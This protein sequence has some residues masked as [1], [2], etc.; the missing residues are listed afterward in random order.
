[1]RYMKRWYNKMD[2]VLQFWNRLIVFPPKLVAWMI[3]I[4]CI[5]LWVAWCV[6]ANLMKRERNKF[7]LFQQYLSCYIIFDHNHYYKN[8]LYIC[9]LLISLCIEVISEMNV[10]ENN[11]DCNINVYQIKLLTSFHHYLSTSSFQDKKD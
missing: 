2:I 4:G 3:I 9:S 6:V 7:L 8:V 10:D 11:W 5:F 1:M